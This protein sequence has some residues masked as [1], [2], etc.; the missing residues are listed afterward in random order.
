MAAGLRARI[1]YATQVPGRVVGLDEC[2]GYPR[3][4]VGQRQPV[5]PAHGHQATGNEQAPDLSCRRLAIEP[6]PALCSGDHVERRRR[7]AGV[8]GRALPP[9]HL[10]TGDS[11]QRAG[12]CEHPGV[13]VGTGDGAPPGRELAS[14]GT[15]PAAQVE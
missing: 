2:L 14:E 8:L 4:R 6:V 5:K 10:Q 1:P 15:G 7:E 12:S 11:G 9:R 13:H 3:H